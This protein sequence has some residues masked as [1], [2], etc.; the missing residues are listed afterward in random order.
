MKSRLAGPRPKQKDFWVTDGADCVSQEWPSVGKNTH[1]VQNTHVVLLVVVRVH[2]GSFLWAL[3]VME[4][5]GLV[6]Q[7]RKK[8]NK[9]EKEKNKRK[10]SPPTANGSSVITIRNSD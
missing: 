10:R 5:I 1:T 9:D 3:I 4:E 6:K 8:Q 7:G 2:G